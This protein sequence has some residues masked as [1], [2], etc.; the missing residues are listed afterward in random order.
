[1]LSRAALVVDSPVLSQTEQFS[2][3]SECCVLVVRPSE[4]LRGS[5]LCEPED[6]RERNRVAREAHM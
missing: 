4:R 3:P 5:L 6:G 2:H 1:M